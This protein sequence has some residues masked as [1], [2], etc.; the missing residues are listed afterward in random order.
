VQEAT[1]W[2]D[3]RP[4]EEAGSSSRDAR[5]TSVSAAAAASQGCRESIAQRRYR[6]T[7]WVLISGYGTSFLLYRTS[8]VWFSTDMALVGLS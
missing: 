2:A 7:V 1:G 5:Q 3:K 8:F 6:V 4:R